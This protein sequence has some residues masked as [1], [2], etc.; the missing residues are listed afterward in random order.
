MSMQYRVGDSD[1]DMYG[2][3]RCDTACSGLRGRERDEEVSVAG[4]V[5]ERGSAGVSRC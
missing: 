4:R 2:M 5:W 3:A 1:V